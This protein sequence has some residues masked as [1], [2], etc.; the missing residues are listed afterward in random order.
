MTNDS[1]DL[2]SF[3]LS[4]DYYHWERDGALST[5]ALLKTASSV[6]DVRTQMD[7]YVGWVSRVQQET[8][9]HGQSVLAEP[10]YMIPNGTVYAGGWCRPQNDGPGLRSGTL[11][12]YASALAQEELQ[13][14]NLTMTG[15]KYT[16]ADLWKYIQIDL[17]WQA[18][19]SSSSE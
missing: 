19:E 11:I 2:R 16:S 8:D 3:F 6:D 4:A 5:G 1:L 12:A 14:K 9:P 10:K 13:G 17:D 7:A 18:F 15:G